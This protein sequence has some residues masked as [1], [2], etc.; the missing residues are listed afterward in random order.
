MRGKLH[1]VPCAVFR[2]GITPAHA[3]KT[4]LT[5]LR[6]PRSGD[7]PRACGENRRIGRVSAAQEGSPPRM[8]GKRSRDWHKRSGQG[9]TPAHAGKTVSPRAGKGAKRDHPRACGENRIADRAV[10]QAPGSPPRMRGKLTAVSA[11]SPEAGITPAHAGKTPATPSDFLSRRDH[12]R[13]CGENTLSVGQLPGPPGSPPRMRGKLVN[14]DIKP[15]RRGI[16]PAHAGKTTS[17]RN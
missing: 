8:R 10:F 15:L 3:G 1:A 2:V 7:H 12:P 16:T 14:N 9:I 13:A 4:L 17:T 5:P 11:C 6:N